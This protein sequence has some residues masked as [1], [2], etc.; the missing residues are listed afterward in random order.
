MIRSVSRLGALAVGALALAALIPGAGASAST[1]PTQ[2]GPHQ[3]F[4]GEINGQTI[5]AQVKVACPVAATHGRAL[6]GQTSEVTS[7]PVPASNFGRTGSR[8]TEIVASLTPA[9]AGES[10][11]FTTYNA[12]QPF[13]TNINVPCG[14]T[15]VI[16]FIPVPGSKTAKPATVTVTYDNVATTTP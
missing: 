8:A 7:S 10:L 3:V 5:N 9:S 4:A 11:V 15:S 1:S 14:G 2:V 16:P 12:P 6:P 13:P